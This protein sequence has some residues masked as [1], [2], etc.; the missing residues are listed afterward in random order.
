MNLV[1]NQGDKIEKA[2]A[3][4]DFQTKYINMKHDGYVLRINNYYYGVRIEDFSPS[5]C[6]A[7]IRFSLFGD[8]LLGGFTIVVALFTAILFGLLLIGGGLTIVFAIGALEV[9]LFAFFLLGGGLTIVFA[10]RVFFLDGGLLAE[11]SFF[12]FLLLGK[13]GGCEL[14]A[15]LLLGVLG[16]AVSKNHHNLATKRIV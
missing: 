3:V 8:L 14:I 7:D 5:E 16:G 15:C 2:M 11:E 9:I 12:L 10:F 6:I 1:D 4:E 13:F